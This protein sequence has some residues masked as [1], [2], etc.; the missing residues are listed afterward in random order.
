MSQSLWCSALYN[1]VLATIVYHVVP[2]E[3]LFEDNVR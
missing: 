2:H 3:H 1:R